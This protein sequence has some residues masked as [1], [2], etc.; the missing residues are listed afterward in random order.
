MWLLLSAF[1]GVSRLRVIQVTHKTQVAWTH[2]AAGLAS[3]FS[4]FSN[5]HA[6]LIAVLSGEV[7]KGPS[8][9]WLAHGCRGKNGCPVPH[10]LD[11]EGL[12]YFM[13]LKFFGSP[14]QSRKV[15]RG[16][17]KLDQ[18]ELDCVAHAWPLLPCCCT[19]PVGL[20]VV[21]MYYYRCSTGLPVV[22][23]A[24]RLRIRKWVW[25]ALSV[26]PWLPNAPW[27]A[28]TAH[29]S[30]PSASR[31]WWAFRRDCGP[32]GERTMHFWS[33]CYQGRCTKGP[34]AWPP[35]PEAAA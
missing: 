13:F 8:A 19:G 21:L 33:R 18:I 6:L 25:A 9:W 30:G 10:K 14:K 12:L 31:S 27:P 1:G 7:H 24:T 22:V 28:A 26:V 34:S 35:H 29:W 20:H 2:H 15:E 4:S 3:F 23:P 16:R 17:S 5:H 11:G 32:V